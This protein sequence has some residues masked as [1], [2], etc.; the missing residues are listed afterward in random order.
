MER[1][2]LVLYW[3]NWFNYLQWA[4][5][6]DYVLHEYDRAMRSRPSR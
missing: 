5:C 3:V 2:T 4:G 1:R 6:S